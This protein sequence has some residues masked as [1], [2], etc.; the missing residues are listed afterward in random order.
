DEQAT[1]WIRDLVEGF[2]FRKTA[3]E[4]AYV[5]HLVEVVGALSR[6]GECV[7]VGRGAP[8]IL[9]AESTLRVRLVAPRAYRVGVI[10]KAQGLSAE[11]A[12][13]WVDATDRERAVFVKQHF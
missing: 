7:I 10:Q 9:P 1:S 11:D 13:R 6:H 4:A 2:S 3:S 12:G 5:R 8:H